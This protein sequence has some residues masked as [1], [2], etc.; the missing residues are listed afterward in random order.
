MRNWRRIGAHGSP[1]SI[2]GNRLLEGAGRRE[3][4]LG[5]RAARQASAG[6]GARARRL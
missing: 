2:E 3:D 5:G 1:R 4:G 6:R